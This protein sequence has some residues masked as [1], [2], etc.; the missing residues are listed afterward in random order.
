MS[1]YALTVRSSGLQWVFVNKYRIRNHFRPNLKM[2]HKTQIKRTK[3]YTGKL[4]KVSDIRPEKNHSSDR[5]ATAYKIIA[6]SAAALPPRPR[7]AK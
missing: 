1:F 4:R 5:P 3:K 6:T 2:A 7:P